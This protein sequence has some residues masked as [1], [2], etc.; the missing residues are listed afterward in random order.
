MG[1]RLIGE[2]I[3]RG[4]RDIPDAEW[5][6]LVVLCEDA[7]DATRLCWPGAGEIEERT[8]KAESTVRRLLT[9]LERRKLIKR[10]DA[11]PV[12][13]DAEPV[14]AYRGHR[15]V[16]EVLSMALTSEPLPGR[17]GAHARAE[18]GPEPSGKAPRTEPPSP[19]SPGMSPQSGP[20]AIGPETVAEVRDALRERT[21]RDVGDD[22]ALRVAANLLSGRTGIASP[23]RYVRA[24]IEREVDLQRFLPV[25]DV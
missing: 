24:S 21:G 10:H 16:F 12:R 3:H 9:N 6:V 4:P 2:L 15:T 19:Q 7:R 17:K 20:V 18:R 5:R 13:D 1:V 25:P 23:A 8:G 22:W 14:V 11:P